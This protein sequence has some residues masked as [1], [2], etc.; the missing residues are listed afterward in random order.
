MVSTAPNRNFILING[1]YTSN[2]LLLLSLCRSTISFGI[3]RLSV[4]GE[5]FGDLKAVELLV[6][7]LRPRVHSLRKAVGIS[8]AL[9]KAVATKRWE[10]ATKGKVV[11]P[12]TKTL[13]TQSEKIVA[14]KFAP[15]HNVGVVVIGR[16]EGQRLVDCLQSL[17]PFI[18]RTVYVDSGSTDGSLEMARRS[19]AKV[20]SLDLSIPFTAARARNEGF[21][22]AVKCWPNLAF[23]QF[24]DGD[25]LV[26]ENWIGIGAEFLCAHDDAAVVSGRLR[27][28][29]PERSVFNALN[30]SD[31][32]GGVAGETT[33]CGGNSL[34]RVG[35]FAQCGGYLNSLIAG[36]EPELCVRLREAGSTVWALDAEMVLHDLNMMHFTQWW[37]RC[38]RTGYAF[39]EVSLLHAGSSLSPWRRS[40][41][42]AIFWAGAL[43]LA[44]IACSLLFP[45]AAVGLFGLYPLQILRMSSRQGI[46]KRMAW[47]RSIFDLIGKFPELLG[48]AKFCA[49]HLRKRTQTLIEYK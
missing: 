5:C 7:L 48:I 15:V 17:K 39:A 40:V 46:T 10:I 31:W 30:D 26:D 22:V 21:T 44:V 6:I 43:P 18:D 25:C 3:V 16:N 33:I 37:R 36:E 42:R 12:S 49:N 2:W 35:A 13:P 23:V 20:V 29:F 34:M 47:Q 32:S 41:L 24:V 28:R 45:P 11:V 8:T 14:S 4:A 1:N 27:E 9:V 19:G 38:V